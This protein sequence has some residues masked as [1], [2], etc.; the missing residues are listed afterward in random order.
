MA[1]ADVAVQYDLRCD[2]RELEGELLPA[3]LAGLCVQDDV[4]H[5]FV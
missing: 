2:Y 5:W 4:V 1:V 3:A